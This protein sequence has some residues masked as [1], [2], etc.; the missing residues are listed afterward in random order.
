MTT[1][2]TSSCIAAATEG[3]SLIFG[4]SHPSWDRVLRLARSMFRHRPCLI[5]GVAFPQ[6]LA[7]AVGQEAPA[8]AF[9]SVPLV[10]SVLGLP[11]SCAWILR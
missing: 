7:S 3:C 5:I 8:P 11:S 2:R 1:A 6:T 9:A 4:T 10:L